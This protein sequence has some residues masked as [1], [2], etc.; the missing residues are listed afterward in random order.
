MVSDLSYR[1]RLPFP[2]HP[3]FLRTC[4]CSHSWSDRPCSDLLKLIHH[5][6]SL[7]V[8]A[9]VLQLLSQM[10][11]SFEYLVEPCT[12]THPLRTQFSY[13]FLPYISSPILNRFLILCKPCQNCED[14]LVLELKKFPIWH[15]FCR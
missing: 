5:S 14:P 4:S 3:L 8:S 1:V 2:F 11:Y 9:T 15:V 6:A 12:A 13:H 7:Q 10:L